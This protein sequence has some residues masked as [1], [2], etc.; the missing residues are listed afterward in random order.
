M[1]ASAEDLSASI[2]Q[3]SAA[4][5]PYGTA[6]AEKPEIGSCS[7]R[8]EHKEELNFEVTAR[9]LHHHACIT[10]IALRVLKYNFFNVQAMER[11]AHARLEKKMIIHD[12]RERF[13]VLFKGTTTE[14]AS[15][16]CVVA[17]FRF[18]SSSHAPRTF[19]HMR[20]LKPSPATPAVGLRHRG[21]T[22][23]AIRGGREGGAA[24]AR[25]VACR[26]SHQITRSS[27][28]AQR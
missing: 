14:P 11:D 7:S 12:Y 25:S 17:G 24:L 15:Q 2:F 8:T 27:T 22:A 19:R 23:R 21:G 20:Q 13:I 6:V 4:C 26:L 1:S 18:R 16:E 9:M 5:V 3:A 28:S 10:A